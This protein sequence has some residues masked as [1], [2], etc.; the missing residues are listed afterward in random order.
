M[1]LTVSAVVEAYGNVL[2]AV[3]VEVITPANVEAVVEVDVNDE[4][5]MRLPKMSPATESFWPGVVVPIPTLPFTGASA[6]SPVFK[7]TTNALNSVND[8]IG[9]AFTTK[10]LAFPNAPD[11]RVSNRKIPPAVEV[12]LVVI[13]ET[14]IPYERIFPSTSVKSAE[15]V[16][17]LPV[18]INPASVVSVPAV[19]S[20]NP[21]SPSFVAIWSGYTG[22]DVPIPTFPLEFQMPL[23]K[24]ALPL[25]VSAVVEAYTKREV[26]DAMSP[27]VNQIG[28]EVEFAAA[29]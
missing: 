19:M 13:C 9:Y 2:A 23:G 18:K 6:V 29:P 14:L 17:P 21:I 7:S 5:M 26:D 25:T 12:S 22:D 8:P 20:P 24:Y 1:P 10:L 16:V 3:A 11:V 27:F 4:P 28:V 15:V